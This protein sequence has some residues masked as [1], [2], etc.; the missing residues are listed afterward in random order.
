MQ[1]IRVVAAVIRRDETVLVC[2]RPLHKRHGGL[3]EFPGGKLEAGETVLDAARREL[4]EELGVHVRC[5]GN[6]ISAIHDPESPFVIEF[7]NVE[8]EG[9]PICHEHSALAWL[10]PSALLQH[11][12]APSDRQFAAVLASGKATSG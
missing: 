2:E 3:W 11:P 8:I 5:I 10:T 12:L 9:D 6:Q 7:H 4:M 1:P